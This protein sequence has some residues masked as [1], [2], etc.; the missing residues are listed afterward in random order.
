MA[1]ITKDNSLHKRLWLR[2]VNI[3]FTSNRTK[4]IG[5]LLPFCTHSARVAHPGIIL[6]FGFLKEIGVDWAHGGYA[7]TDCCDTALYN[8]PHCGG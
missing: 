2:W 6:G 4:G 5:A 8:R 7:G 1:L 3:A